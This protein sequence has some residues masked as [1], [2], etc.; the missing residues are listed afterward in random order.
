MSTSNAHC[1]TDRADIVEDMLQAFEW[2]DKPCY[3]PAMQCNVLADRHLPDGT[4]Q[5][6]VDREDLHG[7]T[8]HNAELFYIW[9]VV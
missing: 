8:A 6:I 9:H 3:W 2:F 5:H 1:L 4:R 7:Q